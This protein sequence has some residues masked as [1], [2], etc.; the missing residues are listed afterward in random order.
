MKSATA[1]GISLRAAIYARKSTDD[2]DRDAV[3]KSVTRQIDHA[4]DYAARNGWTVDPDLIFTDDGISGAEYVNRPGLARLMTSLRH[5]D[6]LV[7]SESS[8]LGRDMTRNAA[9][10]VNI[11]E[12]GKRI[13]YYL[14][15]EEERADTPEQKI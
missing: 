14:T 8:R 13:L 6:V 3:N 4:K 12:S 10:V 9:F 7:M 2:N 11:I 1:E 5:F 15:G